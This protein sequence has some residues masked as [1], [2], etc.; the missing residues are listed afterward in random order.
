MANIVDLMM[1]GLMFLKPVLCVLIVVYLIYTIRRQVYA[2]KD[3]HVMTGQSKGLIIF[4]LILLP[5]VLYKCFMSFIY[6]TGP[7]GTVWGM[8]TP[9]VPTLLLM[10]WVKKIDA[11]ALLPASNVYRRLSKTLLVMSAVFIL[12]GILLGGMFIVSMSGMAQAMGR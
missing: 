11:R 12:L 3:G 2:L 1:L 10:L 4:G 7:S 8:M 6:I 5:M 9:L